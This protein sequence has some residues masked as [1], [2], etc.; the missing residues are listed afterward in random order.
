MKQILAYVLCV[1]C[2]VGISGC[3]SKFPKDFPK[4]YPIQVTVVDGSTPLSDIHV[5]FLRASAGSGGSVSISG[6]TDASGVA[7]IQ[8][9]QG[10]FST[11]GIPAGE[12]VVTLKDYMKLD[13]G[14][15]ADEIAK[16]SRAEQ[17][18]LEK[19]RQ[20]LIKAYKLKVPESL[21]KNAKNVT[22]RSPIRFTADKKNEL[23]IDVS[24]YK[25]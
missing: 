10:S 6:I 5:S 3:G 9:A 19:K 23:K 22:D 1:S 12:Y 21:C 24:E 4:V 20:E 11:S 7:Q 17:G 14:V 18:E 13:L 16:M 8:T 15:T 2:C 25:K